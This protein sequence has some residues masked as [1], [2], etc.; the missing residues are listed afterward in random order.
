G[1]GTTEDLYDPLIKALL[2]ELI[3]ETSYQAGK[4]T[5][6][7]VLSEELLASLKEKKPEGGAAPEASLQTI[8][9][10][11]ALAPAL[12]KALAEELAPALVKALNNLMAPKK[13]SQEAPSKKKS[14]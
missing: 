11:E 9:V 1:Q 2:K 5:V 6:T 3:D 4:K 10:A 12:A 7:E 8:I 14:E 13:T